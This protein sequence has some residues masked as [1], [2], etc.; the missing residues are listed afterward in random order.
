MT[1]MSKCMFVECVD[2]LYT[3]ALDMTLEVATE[4]SIEVLRSKNINCATSNI[5]YVL[6][7]LY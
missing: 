3:E 1:R 6:P 2:L 5:I 7:W 4:F